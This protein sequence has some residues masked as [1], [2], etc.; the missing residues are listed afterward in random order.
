MTAL[1][2]GCTNELWLMG[3]LEQLGINRDTALIVQSNTDAIN[4][5]EKE[6]VE[7]FLE[8]SVST[9]SSIEL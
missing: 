7:L 9:S 6:P 2:G 4:W 3:V 5:E 1:T 8:M